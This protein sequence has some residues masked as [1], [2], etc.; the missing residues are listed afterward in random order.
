MKVAIM[1][2]TFFP[3]VGY[4]SLIKAVDL[5]VFLDDVEYS[6]QSWQTRNHFCILGQSQWLS[7]PVSSSTKTIIKDVKIHN[8]KRF[9]NKMHRTLQQSYAKAGNSSLLPLFFDYIENINVEMLGDFNIEVIK[10]FTKYLDINTQFLKSSMLEIEGA[11]NDKV[12]SILHAVSASRYIC[13]PGS[14]DYMIEFG[15][16]KFCCP[17]EFYDYA[18]SVRVS[19]ANKY[20]NNM[21]IF[22]T[23]MFYSKKKILCE[24]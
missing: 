4:F 5:F 19:N 22:D 15:L 20:G 16:D 14:R 12:N 24:I 7:I 3:W 2:P 18:N 8:P 6:H 21:S 17:V 23:V 13:A 1:Q 11:K 10:F 9:L